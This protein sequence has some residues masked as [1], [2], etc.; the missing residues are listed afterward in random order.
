MWP[1]ERAR[2]RAGEEIVAKP[3]KVGKSC[4]LLTERLRGLDDRVSAKRWREATPPRERS[5]VRAVIMVIRDLRFRHARAT[6]GTGRRRLPPSATSMH[7][8][9][10]RH[11]ACDAGGQQLMTTPSGQLL[12]TAGPKSAEGGGFSA[13]SASAR[14]T[15]AGTAL[16][17]A[18]RMIAGCGDRRRLSSYCADADIPSSSIVEGALRQYLDGTSDAALLLRSLNRPGRAEARTPC[19]LELLSREMLADEVELEKIAAQTSALRG[20]A[21]PAGD[22]DAE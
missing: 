9:R 20:P 10:A 17:Q 19:D 4:A 14:R 12:T 8:G 2:T 6:T 13:T 18:R 15:A 7:F 5:A 16:A 22:A 3:P 1:R 11:D 21:E